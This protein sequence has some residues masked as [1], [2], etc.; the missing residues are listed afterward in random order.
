MRTKFNGILTLLLALVVQISFAQDRTISGTV[1][2]ESGP[3]PGVTVLKKGTTQGTETDFDGN[4][5]LKAKSGDILVF[6]FVGMKT[7]ERAV[8]GSNQINVLL[9]NDNL[10]EEVVVVAYGTQSK[11]S[12]TGSVGVV[13]TEELELVRQ[14]NVVQGIVGKVAGVQVLNNSG[15]P[16]AA[17]TV[18]IRG[19][20]SINASS[21]PLYVVNGVPFTGSINSINPNDIESFTVLKDAAAASLYGSR[22]SNGVIIITTKKGKTGSLSIRADVSTTISTRAV[23][24]YNAITDPGRF[25]EAHF[26][27]M[28]NFLINN[29]NTPSDAAN[30]AAENLI[31]DNANLGY[32]LGYN[33]YNVPNNQVID[34]TTGKL[35]SNAKLLYHEP[36]ADYLF[37]D[38]FSTK[39]FVSADGGGENSKVYFSLGHEENEAYL[40]NSNFER[41]TANFSIDHNFNDKFR[42]GGL[43]NYSHTLQNVPDQGGIAGAFSW[44]RSIAPIYPVFGYDLDGNPILDNNG[45]HIYDFGDGTGGTPQRRNYGSFANPYATALLDIK[46]RTVDNLNG[47]AFFEYNIPFLEGLKFRYN[48]SADLFSRHLISFD[49]GVGGDAGSVGGR[50]TPQ[51]DRTFTL[52]QQQLLTWNRTIGDHS[53][54]VLLG[55]EY[56]R[57]DNVVLSGS[58][59]QFL[60]PDETVLD[61]GINI[62]GVN[63]NEYNYAVEGYF[64]R[65]SY[66]FRNKYFLNASYRRD[67]SSVF[68]PENRW[69]DFYGL[70]A[71]WR[72]SEESFM[73]GA[74]W[75]NELKLKA[76]LGQQGNDRI[77]YPGLTRRNY[78]AYQDQF[79]VTN[80]NGNFGLSL[81]YQGNEDLTWEKSTNFN[82]GFELNIFDGLFSVDFEYFQREVSDLLFNTPQ[83]PSSGLPP[84]P[85]NVG[86]MV[87]KGFEFTVNSQIINNQNFGWS[88]GI[89]G[90][91]YKNE[92]TRLPREFVDAGNFR[93]VEGRSIFDYFRR[94]FAGVNSANGA[95]QFYIDVLDATTGEPTG[96]R[97]L[98]EN[99][100]EA[101]RYFLDKSAI[102]DLYGGF[103][104]NLRYK[105]WNLGINFAYQ[106]GGYGVDNTYNGLLSGNAGTNYHEDFFTQTWTP[107]NTS[108]P[109]PLVVPNNDLNY[110]NASSLQLIDASYLS[111]QNINISYNFNRQ[112]TEK[113]GIDELKIYGTIDNVYL[114][115]ERQGYD[116]RLSVTGTNNNNNFSLVR[117]ATIGVN[118]KL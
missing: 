25:Y 7:V 4:Y 104:T 54:D 35:N 62:Q 108:A 87:N 91:H 77:I 113:L 85:E 32:Q 10:L 81:A 112:L 86:D 105:G 23:E 40:V 28:K 33:V 55:H 9:E 65:L 101:T 53:F 98:T 15:Q 13:K 117:N 16:G 38:G 36:W 115:S 39:S 79:T 8:N 73:Q 100:S 61:L 111:L 72:I 96:E 94:E 19:I 114:W 56:A 30:I 26:M 109:L 2:D 80:N 48:L 102:A 88:V 43:I 47:Q 78:L 29:G 18:R 17:P 75:L 42:L 1:S 89:N 66:N 11:E 14:S 3:L 106:I 57:T 22:G 24:D 21:N 67:A 68:S 84:F 71:G 12:L 76:S 97:E 92:I 31:I 116:P 63:N 64:S 51:A 37:R 83:P 103:G 82:T 44:S 93:Y 34:P 41:V 60:L 50:S 107:D 90:T 74:S 45:V 70:G 20:G 69:G 52:T 59:T 58:K 118:L 99:H 49:T 95:A 6:S 5:S 110:Y 46:K 27:A